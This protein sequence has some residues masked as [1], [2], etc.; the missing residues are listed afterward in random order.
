VSKVA[1][2]MPAVHTLSFVQAN[3]KK[4][5]FWNPIRTGDYAADC[6]Q[7]KQYADELLR[8]IRAHPNPTVIG[9]IVR[10]M[11]ENAAYEAVEIGFC[12]HIGVMLAKAA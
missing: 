3:N 4:T 7:G 9:S 6:K 11:I 8:T 5:N 12:N 10:A 1:S 2:E